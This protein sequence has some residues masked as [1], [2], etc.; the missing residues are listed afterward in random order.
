MGRSG[1]DAVGKHLPDLKTKLKPDVVIINGENAA[2]GIGIT[3]K[4]CEEF[5]AH[6]ADVITTGNHVWD[7][8]EVIPYIDKDPKLLRPANFPKGTPGNG[9]YVHK[10]EDG[11]KILIVNIMARLFMDPL[12][13]PFAKMDEILKASP[14][15][16]DVQAVFV[17]FH[18][19]ATSEKMAMAHYL[20]GRVSAVVGTHTH[21]PT[22]DGQVLPG[23]TALQSDA[24]MTGDYDSVIGMRK[25]I[26]IARFLKKVP[27]ERMVPADG[28]AT[29]CGTFVVTDD[30]GRTKSID[31]VIVGPRLRNTIPPV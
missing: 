30:S 10:L 11:Q 24:G 8:R 14:M 6:G 9:S 31:P 17:D 15:G 4:I 5:Y 29:L 2:H 26:S 19:E 13:D 16:R 20:D 23:G 27:G 22:S 3:G 25:E 7:Q 1:R 21:I 18:G 28:E 12:D